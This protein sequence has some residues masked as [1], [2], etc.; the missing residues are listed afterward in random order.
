LYNGGN[1]I[2]STL[3]PQQVRQKD[4]LYIGDE[5]AVVVR[6]NGLDLERYWLVGTINLARTELIKD[7]TNRYRVLSDIR[8]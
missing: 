5:L 7:G 2:N 3:A 1:T 4:I 6:V 8:D